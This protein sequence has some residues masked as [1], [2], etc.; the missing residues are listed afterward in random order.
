MA[1]RKRT[2]AQQQEQLE[3]ERNGIDNLTDQQLHDA[4]DEAKAMAQQLAD[5]WACAGDSYEYVSHLEGTRTITLTQW[6][7]DGHRG[8][9]PAA[10]TIADGKHTIQHDGYNLYWLDWKFTTTYSRINIIAH[11]RIAAR[12]TDGN[13]RHV[14][15]TI[16]LDNPGS[17]NAVTRTLLDMLDPTAM[18]HNAVYGRK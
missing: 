3:A 6:E 4:L 17:G 9:Y 1:T 10:L 15:A 7:T 18:L 12:V 13:P 2:H 5:E 11:P 16:I 8:Q 14:A